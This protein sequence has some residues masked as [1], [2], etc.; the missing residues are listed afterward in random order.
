MHIADKW[1]LKNS[2]KK[3]VRNE[4]KYVCTEGELRQI[5]GRIRPLCRPDIH[6]GKDGVYRIRSVY[7]DDMDNRCFYENEDGVDPREKFRIRIYNEDF[8]HIFLECKRKERDM[9]QKE[10]CLITK[11]QCEE[12]LGNRFSPEKL[13][14]ELLSEFYVKY[15]DK[16]LKPRVIVSYERTALTFPAGNVRITFDRNI[17]GTA[18]TAQFFNTY[19]P[20]RPVMPLGQHILEVKYDRLLPDFLYALMDLGD[21]VQTSYSKYYFCRKFTM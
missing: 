1:N 20:T 7:F 18:K 10:S 15:R 4:L 11:K 19:L 13:R 5:A 12:L 16:N 3:N 9:T 6:A 14:N 2:D 8:S 17:G 21:L